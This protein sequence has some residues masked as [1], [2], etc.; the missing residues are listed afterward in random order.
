MASLYNVDS[1]I[2]R[3]QRNNVNSTFEDIQRQIGGVVLRAGEA[4]DAAIGVQEQLNT[5]V[6]NGDSSVEA[7][8][9][10]VDEE[11]TVFTTLKERL[12]EKDKIVQE[13]TYKSLL[14]FGITG[15]G[16]ETSKLQEAI[17]YSKTNRCVLFTNKP[18]T[19]TIDAPINV[20]GPL[21]MDCKGLTIIKNNN[22]VGSGSNIQRNGAF[23]VTYDKDAVF[24]LKFNNN[25]FTFNVNIKGVKFQNNN[26]PD[27]MGIFA[28]FMAESTFEN[29]LFSGVKNGIFGYN[30][31]LIPK[32]SNIK[33]DSGEY[34]LR[35]VD[36]GTGLGSSTSLNADSVYSTD[37][38]GV[39]DLFGLSYSN[40][41]LPLADRPTGVPF[42][43]RF[44]NGVNVNSPSTEYTQGGNFLNVQ[45]GEV[46]V[47]SPR[48]YNPRAS[49]QNVESAIFRISNEANV[50]V[51]GGIVNNYT[52]FV[53]NAFYSNFPVYVNGGKIQLNGTRMPTNAQDFFLN[54]N[55]DVIQ[56]NN[57]TEFNKITK[58]DKVNS[59]QKGIVESGTNANGT[60]VRFDDGTMICT[61]RA[62]SPVNV[63]S[64]SLFRSEDLVL[65]LPSAFINVNYITSFMTKGDYQ[66]LVTINE[67][68]TST[69]NTLHFRI[70]SSSSLANCQFKITLVGKWK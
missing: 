48:C 47:N 2:T 68:S 63:S 11:G 28:P 46:V 4:K 20:T 14:D 1:P 59:F 26:G 19:I 5:I 42:V 18:L 38:L 45:G 44:C 9:A 23:T 65:G 27:S 43:L 3:E 56:Q 22:S 50:M 17:D 51:N 10:R 15:V 70:M 8:Q 34:V 24:I 61:I 57:G 32:M 21:D 52:D 67:L 6:V 25:S 69:N 29:L 7:A 60:Y 54:L 31:Y 33:M 58:A 66:A 53:G 64:G 41:N 39:F 13:S 62:L 36:D 37:S 30:W 35:L 49:S 55:S 16:I 12:D 40:I